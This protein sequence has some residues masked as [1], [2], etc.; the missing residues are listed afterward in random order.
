MSYQ[1]G[2]LWV[3]PHLEWGSQ[4]RLGEI[5]LGFFISSESQDH[6]GV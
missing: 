1:M 4:S 5:S 3:Y 6:L 2:Y